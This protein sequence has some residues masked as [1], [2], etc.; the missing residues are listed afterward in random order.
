MTIYLRK[1]QLTSL[2]TVLVFPWTSKTGY[3]CET[4]SL[5]CFLQITAKVMPG[6]TARVRREYKGAL[7]EIL[8]NSLKINTYFIR[9]TIYVYC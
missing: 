1:N 8:A 6:L 9:G 4:C 5:T 7:S 2:N 3:P